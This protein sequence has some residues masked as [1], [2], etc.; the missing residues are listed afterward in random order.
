MKKLLHIEMTTAET[1]A[2]IV[3]ISWIAAGCF[4]QLPEVNSLG[5]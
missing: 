1:I 3:I 5:R 2:F 4:I